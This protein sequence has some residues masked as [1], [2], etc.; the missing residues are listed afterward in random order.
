MSNKVGLIGH[1]ISHSLS[2]TIH[3]SAFDAQKL[4]WK[5]ELYPMEPET[6]DVE[7]E[8]LKKSGVKGFNITAP[9]KQ[10]IVPHLQRCDEISALLG[11]VNTAYLNQDG[12]W[13]GTNTDVIGLRR[14]LD[15][16]GVSKETIQHVAVLGNGGVAR[17]VLSV[18]D[19]LEIET[20]VVL[21]RDQRKSLTLIDIFSGRN[22]GW[23]EINTRPLSSENIQVE[24]VN[25]QL[26]INASTVGMHQND[27]KTFISNVMS[28][29]QSLTYLD[30]V[31]NPLETKMMHQVKQAGGGAINGLDMLIYQAAASYRI[32][33]GQDAPINVMKEAVLRRITQ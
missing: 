28:I 17:A 9:Y 10:M 13:C 1:P 29:P 6:F 11:A 15:E 31:Y 23:K 21:G 4:D 3:Q 33:T 14:V 27:V 8:K 20:V 12:E 5:Y 22:P 25:A 24:L 7:I 2:P 19:N 32:W 26:M 30:L 16:L 18:M